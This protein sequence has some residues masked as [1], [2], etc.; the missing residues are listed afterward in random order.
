MKNII[1]DTLSYQTY[2]TIVRLDRNNLFILLPRILRV[3]I[4]TNI[5]FQGS[6]TNSALLSVSLIVY[7]YQN[8]LVFERHFSSNSYDVGHLWLPIFQLL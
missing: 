7:F 1:T 5:E 6:C 8:F 3:N 4:L 2:K